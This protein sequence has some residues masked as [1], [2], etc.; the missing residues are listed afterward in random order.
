MSVKIMPVSDL[1]RKVSQTIKQVQ[2]KGDAVYITQHGRPQ[3]VLLGYDHYENLLEQTKRQAELA[4]EA[5]LARVRAELENDPKFQA[6][7]EKRILYK[8]P[9]GGRSTGYD[10]ITK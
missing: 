2:Q 3:A 1:R 9:G 5:D 4:E 6:L 8:L 10:L 7:I